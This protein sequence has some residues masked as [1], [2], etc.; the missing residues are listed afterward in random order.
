MTDT[1]DVLNAA[2][3]GRVTLVAGEEKAR[4]VVFNVHPGMP[5]LI[6]I[7]YATDQPDGGRTIGAA[8]WKTVLQEAVSS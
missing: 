4:V 5:N 6:S 7:I 1:A 2:D 3:L 8:F